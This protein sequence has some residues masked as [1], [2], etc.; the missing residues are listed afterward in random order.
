MTAIELKDVTVVYNHLPALKDVTITVEEGTFLGL[1]GPNG[2]GKTTILKLILGLIK[3]KQGEVKVFGEPP[4]HA[5]SRGLVGYVPQQPLVDLDFPVSVFDV[6]MMGRYPKIGLMKRATELDRVKV[7]EKLEQV[8][9]ADL[10]DRPI[11][12]LSGGQQQRAFIARAL[13]SEPKILLLDE[14]LTGI[15]TGTQS[16]FY[17]LLKNL[18]HQL[19]LTVV[20]ASH[21]VGVI[22]NH[23]DEI[24]CV[25]Q[26][27]HIHGKP[28]EV[29][30]VDGL[31][32]VY[33]CEVELLVHG[34]IPHRVVREHND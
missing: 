11:G 3:P 14:P 5:R 28:K 20:M 21:D 6:V 19:N 32:K 27:L 26:A 29:L 4:E 34:R 16:A 33:G 24:A 22:P 15:D 30:T 23:T 10:K 25:N 18:K 1:I 2:G 31:K 12:Q 13:V 8:G 17:N 7:I 9:M